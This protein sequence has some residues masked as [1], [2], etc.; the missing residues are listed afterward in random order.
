MQ[1]CMV[2]TISVGLWRTKCSIIW[3]VLNICERTIIYLLIHF[4]AYSIVLTV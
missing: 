1:Q 3:S 4:Y 2:F